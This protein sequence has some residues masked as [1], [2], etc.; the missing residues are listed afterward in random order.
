MP[1]SGCLKGSR[2]S[3]FS[4]LKFP[5]LCSLRPPNMSVPKSPYLGG[6]NWRWSIITVPVPPL[7]SY[8]LQLLCVCSRLCLP[9]P[10]WGVMCLRCFITVISKGCSTAHTV[11]KSKQFCRHFINMCKY[12]FFPC[13]KLQPLNSL[14]QEWLLQ[15]NRRL[16]FLRWWNTCSVTWFIVY[17]TVNI[18]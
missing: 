10:V 13:P 5:S 4:I 9:D 8:C 17:L 6:R 1:R 11:D 12:L 16:W 2:K 3:A 15:L 7:C 18:L 14:R